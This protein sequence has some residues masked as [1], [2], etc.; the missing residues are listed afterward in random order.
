MR[1]AEWQVAA[2][3]AAHSTEV[4]ASGPLPLAGSGQAALPDLA[5][6]RVDSD[7]VPASARLV[8]GLAVFHLLLRRTEYS[9]PVPLYP[10]GTSS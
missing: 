4:E 8:R 5:Q 3:V 7:Q 2:A 1:S 6:P 9:H 10:T